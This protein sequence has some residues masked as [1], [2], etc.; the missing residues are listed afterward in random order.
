MVEEATAVRE[1]L[2]VVVEGAVMAM[3]VLTQLAIAAV[4]VVGLAKM[5]AW[6]ERAATEGAAAEREVPQVV[7]VEPRPSTAPIPIVPRFHLISS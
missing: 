6:E 4:S 1:A 3:A 7:G 2:L 5:V